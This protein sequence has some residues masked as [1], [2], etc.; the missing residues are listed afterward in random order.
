MKVCKASQAKCMALKAV[1]EQKTCMHAAIK[2]LQEKAKNL[3]FCGQAPSHIAQKCQHEQKKCMTISSD[4]AKQKACWEGKMKELMAEAN[5][6]SGSG[7]SM[8]VCAIALNAMRDMM[9]GV[10][11]LKDVPAAKKM[12]MCK[13]YN[14]MSNMMSHLAKCTSYELKAGLNNAKL[15]CGA[16]KHGSGS[17]A[18]TH[19]GFDGARDCGCKSGYFCNYDN[20]VKGGCEACSSLEK[21]HH[22]GLPQK[23]VADCINRC[24]KD[25]HGKLDFCEGAPSE[26][27]AKVCK[28]EQKN[29]MTSSSDKAEQKACW[30]AKMKEMS[31][32]AESLANGKKLVAK[33]VYVTRMVKKKRVVATQFVSKDFTNPKFKKEKENYENVFLTASGASKADSTVEYTQAAKTKRGRRLAEGSSV[34]NW[35]LAY[36][37]DVQ[38][39][40]ALV[41]VSSTAFSQAVA[42]HSGVDVKAAKASIKVFEVK[43]T[44][45]TVKYEVVD[46]KPASGS[47][48]G[49]G[50]PA[51]GSGGKAGAGGLR[52]RSPNACIEL[53]SDVK[54]KRI[55]DG[56]LGLD[57]NVHVNG[58]VD[59]EKLYIGGMSIED[60]V[61]KL[62]A[63][64]LK[65]K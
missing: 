3:D 34:A 51:A 4:K 22:A 15:L 65:K 46:A 36:N 18:K 35:I 50:K 63:E 26:D 48:S 6:G 43:V 1:A 55:G 42:K 17:G 54:I 31:K 2:E 40:A 14:S 45:K 29:C 8:D 62:V 44:E 23:G 39:S 60:I 30:E 41:K 49:K 13:S 5:R 21:C 57:A 52:I 27:L 64:A 58:A 37:N 56:K 7:S 12:E 11:N 32:L 28:E 20:G 38:A 25:K 9:K 19:I 10:K 61:R 59:V 33:T 47:G 24:P 53:G 16:K